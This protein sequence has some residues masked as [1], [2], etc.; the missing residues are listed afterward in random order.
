MI[1]YRSH[2]GACDVDYPPSVAFRDIDELEQA[3]RAGA[4][5]LTG[6]SRRLHSGF[7]VSELAL[8]VVLLVAAGVL[9]RT[10][11]LC[12]AG[13]CLGA[14]TT[15]AA[16]RLLAAVLYGV[17]PRD[18]V[19][20]CAALFL[21]IAVALLACWTPAMRAIRTDPAAFDAAA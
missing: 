15:L 3:L 5:T 12:A 16:G 1:D 10:L 4:R 14:I 19:T 9:G 20:Y 11:L 8:A 21:M 17:S 13:T 7:V 2:R 18:P 6:S